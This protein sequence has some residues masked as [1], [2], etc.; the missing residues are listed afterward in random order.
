MGRSYFHWELEFPEIFFDDDG[1]HKTRPGFDAVVGN[2]PY[3]RIQ[4]A[5][6]F[7]L[8]YITKNFESASGNVDLYV[9]FIE[10][11]L[12][13]LRE[14]G[15]LGEIVP[16]K[17]LKTD[18]GQGLRKLIAGRGALD[19]VLDFGACQVFEVTIYTCLLFLEN[20]RRRTF[21]YAEVEPS[22]RLCENSSRF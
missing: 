3:V 5:P 18:Y 7:E 4:G 9:S 8:D 6:R 13:L 15:R 11:G 12:R 14:G 1:S 2:P 20:F 19:Q 21:R 17:F 16:N 22:A 10:R